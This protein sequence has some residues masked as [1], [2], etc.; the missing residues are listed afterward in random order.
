MERWNLDYGRI[1]R[2]AVIY[3]V[4]ATILACVTFLL[5]SMQGTWETGLGNFSS[6]MLSIILCSLILMGIC[7]VFPGLSWA[8]VVLFILCNLSALV[9]LFGASFGLRPNNLN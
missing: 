9:A 7:N 5:A 2:P 3:F 8:F 1:C 4:I 6:Q